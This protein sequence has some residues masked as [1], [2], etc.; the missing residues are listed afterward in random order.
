MWFRTKSRRHGQLIRMRLHE[1]ALV[2]PW[3]FFGARLRRVFASRV[4]DLG[5]SLR[6]VLWQELVYGKVRTT[7][8][9][10]HLGCNSV[11]GATV[12]LCPHT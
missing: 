3:R 8:L 4:V 12:G 9:A 5:P 7:S 2:R 1:L 11:P 10:S 6:P